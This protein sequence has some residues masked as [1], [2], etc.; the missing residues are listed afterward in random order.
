MT[1][2]DLDP[3]TLDDELVD[4]PIAN[5]TPNP[6]NRDIGDITDLAAS[7][8]TVGILQPLTVT[9][10]P[11]DPTWRLVAGHRRLAAAKKAKLTEVPCIVKAGLSDADVVELSIVENLHRKDL[12]P[13]EEAES[14]AQLVELGW[15]QKTIAE[16]FTRTQPHVSKRLGLLELPVEIRARVDN[17]GILLDAAAKLVQLKKADEKEFTRYLK[18][19]PSPSGWSLDN[20]I[21]DIARR[22]KHERLAK[23]YVAKGLK[24]VHRLDYMSSESCD[25]KDATLVTFDAWSDKPHFYRPKT[26]AKASTNGT[27][28]PTPAA[29]VEPPKETAK[30]RRAREATEARAAARLKTIGEALTTDTPKTAGLLGRV[31]LS[32]W[33]NWG[34]T[35]EDLA[36]VLQVLGVDHADDGPDPVDPV[37]LLE[38]YAYAGDIHARN[39]G[40]AIALVDTDFDPE[41]R[42]HALTLLADAGLKLDDR[43]K[44]VIKSAAENAT[45]RE[46]RIASTTPELDAC[47]ICGCTETNACEAGCHWVDDP[48][49]IGPLCSECLD[50]VGTVHDP[51]LPSGPDAKREAQAKADS[52]FVEANDLQPGDVVEDDGTITRVEDLEGDDDYEARI[53]AGIDAPVEKLAR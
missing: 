26:A 46:E 49:G 10:G 18:G 31:V 13:S 1:I 50:T 40:M 9:G 15:T 36:D 20:K 23:P 38:Q 29:L 43:D 35:S 21:A 53:K 4:I 44:A 11:D 28:S 12:T 34:P 22:K 7:I 14:Y 52:A 37:D 33:L 48:A 2:T 32:A 17:G 27:A 41:V 19:N 39:T 8:A 42:A 25:Q 24:L 16:R 30:E 47:R 51:E 3:A 45:R 6:R 5:I